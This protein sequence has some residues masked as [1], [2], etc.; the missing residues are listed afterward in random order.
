MFFGSVF[1]DNTARLSFRRGDFLAVFLVAVLI[2][3][4]A[5]AF[6][7]RGNEEGARAEIYVDGEA[8]D[9]YPL[10][11]DRTFTVYGDYANVIEIKGG[12]VSIVKSD[13]PGGDCVRT[14]RISSAGRS[15]VCLPN[16]VEVR[17]TG[18]NEVDFV[19]R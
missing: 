11:E 4:S 13:C 18:D 5:I 16:R 2:F 12:S 15:I 6:F 1:M 14:G 19:V 7:P 10:N 9:S 8:V 3:V 17:I